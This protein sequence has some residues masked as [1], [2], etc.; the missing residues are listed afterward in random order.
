MKYANVFLLTITSSDP[1]AKKQT[2]MVLVP[3]TLCSVSLEIL[4]PKGGMFL[5]GV[6]ELK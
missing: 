2:Q 3:T 4:F 5:L 1:L 6:I